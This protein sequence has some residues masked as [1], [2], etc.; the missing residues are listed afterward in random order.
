MNDYRG[1]YLKFDVFVLADVF[2]K[3]RNLIYY[4]IYGF[5]WSHYLSAPA[6]ILI[7]DAMYHITKVKLEFISN[8]GMYF[9]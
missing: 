1:L 6:L 4:K 7:W 3:F 9:L 8:A 5:C 2:E